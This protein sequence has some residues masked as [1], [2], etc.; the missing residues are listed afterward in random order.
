[1]EMN[2]KVNVIVP[3][4][5]VAEYLPDFLE[6]LKRQTFQNF[7]I[8]VVDDKST[9]HSR[10]LLFDYRE[11]F[12]DN[13]HIICNKKNVGQCQTRNIGL[14]SCTTRGE[15]VVMLDSDDYVSSDFLEKMLAAADRNHADITICGLERFDDRTGKVICREMIH[16][17]EGSIT[18]IENFSL[19][20]YLNPVVWN[21]MYRWEAL[22]DTRF[23][24]IKRS[25]DTVFL[26]T[27]LPRIHAI[28]FINEILYHYRVRE[29]SL[30]GAINEEIY[31][32][33]LD[34]F[35]E[36]K[37]Y[38]EN[39]IEDY[40][41]YMDLFTVQMFIRCGLGGACR[42]SFKDL[43]KTHYYVSYTKKYMDK[44]FKEWRDN[45]Y[46]SFSQFWK[47]K[48]YEKAICIAAFLYKVNMFE[49]FVYGYWFVSTVIKK[50]MRV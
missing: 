24:T 45:S 7:D 19:M 28:C 40:G 21:K 39:K 37:L 14:N 25:E 38:F 29:S 20:G 33:M 3:V 48:T 47:K 11:K 49:L 5:N 32:S 23:T 41:Q 9:D 16:N 44:Y 2:P 8:W 22:K 15:Y 50:D 12:G 31:Y 27:L 18:D 34:G 4:Y 42:L 10:E 30:S 36:T 43:G 1:M 35:A 13:F 17:P 6:S 46:L 26:F